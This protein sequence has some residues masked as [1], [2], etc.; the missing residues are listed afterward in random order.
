MPGL[1]FYVN[2]TFASEKNYVDYVIK[3]HWPHLHPHYKSE[4][5]EISELFQATEM[6]FIKILTNMPT[7]MENKTMP[8]RLEMFDLHSSSK[9]R[10]CQRLEQLLVKIGGQNINCSRYAD[11][12]TGRK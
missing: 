12:T 8:H 6:K 7:D 2:F 10:K 4:V 1:I 5:D 3:G 9:K 11:Y